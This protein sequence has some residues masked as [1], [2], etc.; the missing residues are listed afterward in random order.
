MVNEKRKYS[1]V[2]LNLKV[3][4]SNVHGHN[5]RQD[6]HA[7]I[8]NLS[9]SGICFESSVDFNKGEECFFVFT[10]HNERSSIKIVGN[11]LWRQKNPYLSTYGV[12]LLNP[13]FLDRMVLK[14]FIRLYSGEVS[15]TDKSLVFWE[16]TFLVLLMYLLSKAC[17]L[18]PLG[19]TLIMMGLV[20][21][22][23]YLWLLIKGKK[24]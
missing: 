15:T 13:G 18:L 17:V 20:V 11:V 1:R 22:S 8:I 21:F 6:T 23:F 5:F 4:V 19:F 24:K 9:Q 10:P 12:D 2:K 14:R 7:K 3:V 16:I